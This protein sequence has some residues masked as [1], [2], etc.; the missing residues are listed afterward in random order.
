MICINSGSL[1]GPVG[2]D[3]APTILYIYI[4]MCV[5]FVSFLQYIVYIYIYIY[6][7]FIY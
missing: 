1:S 5:F 2:G 7:F 6:V 4:Y 3:K